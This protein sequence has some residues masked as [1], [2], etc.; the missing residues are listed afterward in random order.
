MLDIH[1]SSIHLEVKVYSGIDHNFQVIQFL[2]LALI[3]TNLNQEMLKN[4]KYL[5]ISLSVAKC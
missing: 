1:I 4:S 5:S 3:C 2:L